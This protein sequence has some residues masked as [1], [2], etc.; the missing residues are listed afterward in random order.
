MCDT[1][2]SLHTLIEFQT[3]GPQKNAELKDR[4]STW[5]IKL[6][7][8]DK[9]IIEQNFKGNLKRM[10]LHSCKIMNESGM[11]DQSITSDQIN[12]MISLGERGFDVVMDTTTYLDYYVKWTVDNYNP[13][14][15]N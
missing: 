4:F 12:L 1:F 3:V 10:I 5:H 14:V 13:P 6:S 8:K 11:L 15:G 9:K 2:C 7:D